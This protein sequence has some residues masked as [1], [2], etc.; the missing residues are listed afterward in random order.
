MGK[1][2]GG[3]AGRHHCLYRIHSAHKRAENGSASRETHRRRVGNGFTSRNTQ[4]TGRQWP[5]VGNG[6]QH[7]QNS[8]AR[9]DPTKKKL[10]L[11]W[12]TEIAYVDNG[13]CTTAVELFPQDLNPK[14]CSERL[15][16]GCPP[17]R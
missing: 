1:W 14:R 10:Q 13:D 2:V 5:M 9:L 16:R 6:R 8:S 12:T 3:R 17:A 7:T 15:P 11:S 4:K